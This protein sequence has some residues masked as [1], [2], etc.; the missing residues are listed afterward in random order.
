MILL[1]LSFIGSF[2][3]YFRGN[4]V[5]FFEKD[6]TGRINRFK[7]EG[8]ISEYCPISSA[9]ATL[10]EEDMDHIGESTE[11]ETTKG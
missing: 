1:K 9:Q 11:E 3:F 6:R 10:A 8:T 2:F 5:G 4:C 7:M